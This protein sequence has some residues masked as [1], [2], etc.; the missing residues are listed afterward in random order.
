MGLIKWPGQGPELEEERGKDA[1]RFEMEGWHSPSAH[2]RRSFARSVVLS[3]WT[4]V[5]RTPGIKLQ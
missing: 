2:V 5:T 3:L 4:P 1:T